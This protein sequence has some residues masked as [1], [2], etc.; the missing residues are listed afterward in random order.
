MLKHNFLFVY[1]T[2]KL[3]EPL[4]IHRVDDA[5]LTLSDEDSRCFL[6]LD[7]V[8]QDSTSIKIEVR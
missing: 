2:D 4:E 8:H 6:Q 7:L 5:V 1:K 3:Q